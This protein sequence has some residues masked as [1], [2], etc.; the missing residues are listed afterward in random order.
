MRSASP[1]LVPSLSDD[2]IDAELAA[3]LAPEEAAEL[4]ATR[5]RLA[6]LED[7]AERAPVPPD[8]ARSRRRAGDPR[9]LLEAAARVR[10]TSLARE[11]LL[12]VVD[13]LAPLLPDA[14][15]RRGST[16]AVGSAEPATP[17]G[18][19]TALALALTAAASVEG[20]WTA[21]VGLP[22]VGLAA[23]AELGLALERLAVIAAPP[24]EQWATVV[25]ALVGAF[26]LVL[27]PVPPA[28]RAAEV[29]RLVA[30]ARERGSVLIQLTPSTPA[31]RSA[32]S[33][34]S[35]GR[36]R[37]PAVDDT[38]LGADVR[39]T[40]T[41]AEWQ[42]LDRG[43]GHLRTRRLTV[44]TAGRRR[45]AHPRRTDLWLPGPTG[46]IELVEAAPSPLSRGRRDEV[47]EL[48]VEQAG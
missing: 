12:P 11:Q 42:G 31:A 5:L 40:V 1:L 46:A 44:E 2:D 47:V 21:L 26:D 28:T 34:A 22:A 39:L 35:S 38:V 16:V 32:T 17:V 30:R 4:Q 27:V 20:S 6:A 45:A 33:S 19:A 37:P 14:G 18:G 8:G 41:A 13:E 48:E 25:A 15:L 43:A 29:R 7:E 9:D 23:A 10:P 24:P 36:R 3:G